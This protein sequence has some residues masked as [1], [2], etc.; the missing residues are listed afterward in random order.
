MFG[1]V[2]TYFENKANQSKESIGPCFPNFMSI[3]L[4][5]MKTIILL[6]L[7]YVS[8]QT[9]DCS[10]VQDCKNTN[11]LLL[12]FPCMGQI[13]ILC[14]VVGILNYA[15][16]FPILS[17]SLFLFND[18]SPNTNIPWALADIRTEII[19]CCKMFAGSMIYAIDPGFNFSSI[20]LICFSIADAM[21]LFMHI[22]S[23]SYLHSYIQIVDITG[24][25]ITLIFTLHTLIE[26][27]C[28]IFYY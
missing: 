5:L 1:L 18:N 4:M 9:Y 15:F 16:T 11:I 12:D 10:D 22:Y 8:A 13:H 28:L 17:L 27:V 25:V 14:I 21:S 7:T 3:Y 20:Y 2:H 6:P 19:Y 23:N 26:V 24:I